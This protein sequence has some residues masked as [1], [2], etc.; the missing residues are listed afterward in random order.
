MSKANFKTLGNLA[1]RLRDDLRTSD[2]VLLFAHNGTGKTRLSME[3]KDR[4]KKKGSTD[5]IYFNAY[6]EDLF[7]WDNDLENDSVR[8]LKLNSSSRF[9]EG[10]KEL[11]MDNKIRPLLQRYVDFDFRT[12][13]EKWIISFSRE[14]TVQVNNR[15]KIE[16]KTETIDNIKVSRGEENIFIWCVFLAIC[17]LA[18]DGAESYKWVKNI[19]IDDPI[20]SLDENNAIAVATD[21]SN[22]IKRGKDKVK[23]VISSHHSLFFNI[24]CN[25]IKKMSHKRYFL[26]K[27]NAHGYILQPT[28]E[29]PFFHHVALLCE[30]KAAMDTDTIKTYHFNT[31]RSILEKTSVFFGYSDFSSCISGIDDEVLYSRALN[32]LSHGKYSIYEPTEMNQDNKELFKRVFVSFLEKY[33][34]YLPE[35]LTEDK[36]KSN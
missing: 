4:A 26:H 22:L 18:I 35:L 24:M 2:Y 17:E 7:S 16:E 33:Q 1:V 14:V 11:D 32:L 29:T 31:L 21:L 23:T 12:D 3:F 9:V 13:Y 10:F 19:Y 25:E 30:L 6:T 5:T 15:G 28:D 36:T 8:V 20:S 27:S 34:F